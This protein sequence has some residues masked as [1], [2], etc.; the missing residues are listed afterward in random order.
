[1]LIITITIAVNILLASQFTI[2]PLETLQIHNTFKFPSEKFD[3][4]KKIM[5]N[6]GWFKSEQMWKKATELFPSLN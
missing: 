3:L 2:D 5:F 1:M 4:K 6:K